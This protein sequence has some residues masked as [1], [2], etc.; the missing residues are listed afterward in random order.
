MTSPTTSEQA[1]HAALEA[2]RRLID[3]MGKVEFMP[4]PAQNRSRAASRTA[5]PSTSAMPQHATPI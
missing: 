5:S 4:T 2:L 1:I 3:G